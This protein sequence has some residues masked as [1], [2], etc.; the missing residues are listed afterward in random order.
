MSDFKR[1]L[2][3]VS[4]ALA[5]SGLEAGRARDAA[6]HMADWTDD[7]D[8]LHEVW[9]NLDRYDDEQVCEVLY[10]FLAHVPNHLAA[11]SKLVGSGPV[12]DIFGIGAL[13]EDDDGEEEDGGGLEA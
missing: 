6:F 8:E 13:E 7:L 12:S 1:V 3:R 9:H 5:A 4:S 10:R 11:A 2:D